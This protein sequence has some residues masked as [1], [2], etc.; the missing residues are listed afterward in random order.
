MSN[1]AKGIDREERR[2]RFAGFGS[3]GVCFIRTKVRQGGVVVLCAQLKNYYGTSVTNAVEDIYGRVINQLTKE[4]AIKLPATK[5]WFFKRKDPS[6]EIAAQVIWI[7]HYPQG[8]GMFPN[9]SYAL[10][11]FDSQ[12]SPVWNYVSKEYIVREC[13]VEESFLEIDPEALDYAV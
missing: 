2:F 5:W 4:G 10:V 7:E 12:M 11:S 6:E 3:V 9:G 8:A 1:V 13:G